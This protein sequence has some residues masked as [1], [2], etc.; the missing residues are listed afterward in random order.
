M[1][2]AA[3]PDP[4]APAKYEP[5]KEL[6]Q[7]AAVQ[8]FQGRPKRQP[9]EQAEYFYNVKKTH[10]LMFFSSVAMLVSFILMFWKDFDRPWKP[11]Q[12]QFAAMEFEK[13]WY[14]MNELQA[15]VTAKKAELDR[16]D[17]QIKTFLE[18]FRAAGAKGL[19]LKVGLFGDDPLPVAGL[20]K[21]PWNGEAHVVVDETKKEEWQKK[22]AIVE[23]EKI[24]GDLYNLRQLFNFAKDEQGAIRYK[25]D[26]SKHHYQEALKKSDSRLNAFEHHFRDAEK[27]W[28]AV[29]KKVEERKVKKDEV[30]GRDTFYDDFGAALEKRKIPG[31]WDGKPLEELKKERDR[32][33]KEL[34]DKIVRFEKER[35]SLPNTIRN[36]PGAD[37]FRPT[38]KVEQVILGDVKDQLNFIKIEKVDRC[39][40][41]HV[42][43]GNKYYV[44]D[45]Y[46]DAKEEEDRVR[47]REPFLRLFVAHARGKVEAKECKICDPAG[48]AKP[49][50]IKA[51]LTP[52]GAWSVDDAI[53]FTKSLMAHP[54]LDL[55]VSDSSRHPIAS[56]GC[57]VCHEG[58]GR[59]TDF[60][61]VVHTPNTYEQGQRWK[62]RHGTPY[63]E[64]RYNWNYREL[65]DLPMFPS[66][67]AQSSCRRCHADAVELDGAEKYV[68]GMKLFERAGCYGCHRTE[69]Y[70]IL[71]KDLEN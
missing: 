22:L 30:E 27:E 40:T 53:K 15:G 44:V 36:A 21:E 5:P 39:H 50:G 4:K 58:D 17:L 65:W 9:V 48:R 16:I 25:Y 45:S 63:G 66:K 46:P 1:A 10:I 7:K 54:R 34:E 67:F 32:I 38:R 62:N 57:T 71:R 19:K 23:R 28:D 3:K 70:Q 41:C 52:H 11:Y 35:P 31:V 18:K 55:F 26:E 51:P 6:E 49:N 42:G 29:R 60:T 8:K 56:F 47:F 13:V 64:E 43:I 68:Q 24:R 12:E 14:D 37:F 33:A 20:E 59:D 61:R 69:T 2:D